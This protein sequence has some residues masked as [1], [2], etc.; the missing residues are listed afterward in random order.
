MSE[1]N[2]ARGAR[3][4]RY[5]RPSLPF[6]EVR[7]LERVFMAHDITLNGKVSNI[8]LNLTCTK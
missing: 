3:F 2:D 4:L 1:L 7:L 8:D 5:G 6:T